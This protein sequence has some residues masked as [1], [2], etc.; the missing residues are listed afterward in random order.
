[1]KNYIKPEIEITKIAPHSDIAAAGMAQWIETKVGA[2][3]ATYIS[4]FE[5]VSE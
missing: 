4:T 1:M 5:Y 2:A 3:D